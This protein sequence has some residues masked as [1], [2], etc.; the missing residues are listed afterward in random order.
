MII[1][2]AP[3]IPLRVGNR[4]VKS[5]ILVTPDLNGLIIGIDWLEKQGQFVWNFCDGRIKFED[6][7]WLELQNEEVSRQIRRV[8]ISED[9]IVPAS[10]NV[11]ANVWVAHRAT[12]DRPFVGM[13]EQCKDPILNDIV[14]TRS[15]LPARFADMRVSLVNL[16]DETQLVPKG[17]DLGMLYE[18]QVINIPEDN[19]GEVPMVTPIEETSSEPDEVDASENPLVNWP[20]QRRDGIRGLGKQY[21]DAMTELGILDKTLL[22]QTKEGKRIDWCVDCRRGQPNNVEI[23]VSKIFHHNRPPEEEPEHSSGATDFKFGRY[24]HKVHPNKFPLKIL[25]KK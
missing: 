15:L 2:G 4:R 24:I 21:R 23:R 22:V 5:E 20:Q 16:G 12:D 13:L 7:E 8:Y 9:T 25:E 6:G 10:G 11:K 14:Y 17:T 3:R 18:A 19:E 1:H